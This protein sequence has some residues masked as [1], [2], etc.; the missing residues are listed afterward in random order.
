MQFLSDFALIMAFFSYWSMERRNIIENRII[1]S[2][3]RNAVISL[4][5]IKKI[6]NPENL[7]F[8]PN[9]IFTHTTSNGMTHTYHVFKSQSTYKKFVLNSPHNLYRINT[10]YIVELL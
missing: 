10:F 8:I 2:N 4:L 5:K 7:L 6:S 9:N 1:I 3:M